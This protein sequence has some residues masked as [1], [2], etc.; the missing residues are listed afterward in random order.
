MWAACDFPIEAGNEAGGEQGHTGML[1]AVK[2]FVLGG[3]HRKTRCA[4][5]DQYSG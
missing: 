4:S 1:F 3:S 2:T 5:G